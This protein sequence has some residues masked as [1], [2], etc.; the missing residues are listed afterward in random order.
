MPPAAVV[1]DSASD[2]AATANRAADSTAPPSRSE[3]LLEAEHPADGTTTYHHPD[4]CDRDPR[5]SA[6]APRAASSTLIDASR[7]SIAAASERTTPDKSADVPCGR[8]NLTDAE[9]N[10]PSTLADE[11]TA[12]KQKPEG[13][14]RINV[15]RINNEAAP[16][17]AQ[18]DKAVELQVK[19]DVSTDS[20]LRADHATVPRVHDEAAPVRAQPDKAVELQAKPDDSTDGDLR[21]DLQ[22][23]PTTIYE[24]LRGCHVSNSCPAL[25]LTALDVCAGAG[26]LAIPV[27][28]LGFEHVALIDSDDQCVATLRRNGFAHA[29]LARVEEEDFKKYVGTTLVTAGFPCQPWSVGGKRH[30]QGDS[31]DLWNHAV[32]A[33]CEVNPEMFL[34][35]M[36]QGFM[37]QK[38]IK[39]RQ[40]LLR[41]LSRLG[42]LV[43]LE[44]V[45]AKD[46]GVPQARRRCLIIGQRR[47]GVT[48]RPDALPRMTAGEALRDLGPPGSSPEHVLARH[49]TQG[50]ARSYKGHQPSQ[51]SAP[52]KTIRAG[53]HGPG[54]GNNTVALEDGSVRYFTLREM[55]RL[56]SFPD[57][58]HFN[59]T[60]SRA[61]KEI[62][63]ACPPALVLPWLRNMTKNLLAARE[64]DKGIPSWSPKTTTIM[65][66]ESDSEPDS[67]EEDESDDDD[68]DTTLGVMGG[69]EPYS[70]DRASHHRSHKSPRP[71][72][73]CSSS[74]TKGAAASM[75]CKR[76]RTCCTVCTAPTC[77]PSPRRAR[78][79]WGNSSRHSLPKLTRSRGSLAQT[80]AMP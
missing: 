50:E 14:A 64:Y 4:V 78:S 77:D 3:G 70:G 20:D 21:A 23:D 71:T 49:C 40:R 32:R 15:P 65:D 31:R 37:A 44:D 74:S 62:G 79:P 26:G 68:A 58:H 73:S 1:T 59:P 5:V 41:G 10:R 2:A 56:Q 27:R 24:K 12:D 25:G 34:F 61:V 72:R 22:F 6:A 45:N 80:D 9:A 29:V 63:N 46:Y 42:Y 17:Q 75:H 69:V 39:S 35:E 43:Q 60:W 48:P 53:V 8:G 76:K 33:I 55:A 11:A 36:V 7:I 67:D 18:P 51:L 16:V 66:R 54:G 47:G 30:G 13:S 57:G 52:A 38:F 19:P 28:H